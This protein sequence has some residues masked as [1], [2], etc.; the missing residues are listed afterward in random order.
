MIKN[1]LV[2]YA[3]LMI[4]L[5]SVYYSFTQTVFFKNLGKTTEKNFALIMVIVTIAF[6][7]IL[8]KR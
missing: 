1:K 6:Y 3:I 4:I 2:R 7:N 5:W 8:K